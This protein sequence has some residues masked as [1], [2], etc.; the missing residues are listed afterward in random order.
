MTESEIMEHIEWLLTVIGNLRS[1]IVGLSTGSIKNYT[2]NTGQ[3]TQNVTKKDI[4]TLQLQLKQYLVDLQFYRE[5]LSGDG[6]EIIR[7]L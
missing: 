2:I 6:G 1:V 7:A 3:S 4:S 5:M